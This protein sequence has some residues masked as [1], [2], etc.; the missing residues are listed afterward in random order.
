MSEKQMIPDQS[1]FAQSGDTKIE[2]RIG[3]PTVYVAT[4]ELKSWPEFFQAILE[5]RKTHDLRRADDRTFCVNDLMQLREFD[6][7]TE[8][9]TGREVMV[10]I[11]Y[12]TSVYSPCALS[13]A[14]LNSAYCILSIKKLA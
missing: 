7:K 6:P 14:A 11:T 3:A 10:E 8:R 2:R 9:Y 4:H 5:G 1:A 13:E 12:I